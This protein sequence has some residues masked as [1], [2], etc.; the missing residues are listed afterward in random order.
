MPYIKN[1]SKE[2]IGELNDN[3]KELVGMLIFALLANE[4]TSRVAQ[5]NME[6]LRI[7]LDNITRDWPSIDNW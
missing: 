2:S 1:L 7:E 4:E 5:E 6:G 3:D